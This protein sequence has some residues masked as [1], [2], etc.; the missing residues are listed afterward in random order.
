M[1]HATSAIEDALRACDGSLLSRDER[2]PTH[3][4]MFDPTPVVDFAVQ[5]GAG[6]TATV[7]GAM[8]LDRLRSAS[9]AD[10][11]RIELRAN[12][13]EVAITDPK[14]GVTIV[15]PVVETEE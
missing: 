14:N 12:E 11:T 9:N 13:N 15:V 7:L 2:E 6:V 8:I 1:D 10:T 3:H 5:V 4:G